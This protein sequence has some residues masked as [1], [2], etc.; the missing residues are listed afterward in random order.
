M[1]SFHPITGPAVPLV[2]FFCCQIRFY[3]D[4]FCHT[5]ILLYLDRFGIRANIVLISIDEVT[6]G[7]DCFHHVLSNLFTTE[8]IVFV[9]GKLPRPPIIEQR[10]MLY[11]FQ[12]IIRLYGGTLRKQFR[13]SLRV[14]QYQLE[15]FTS[16]N[17]SSSLE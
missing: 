6:E 16:I 9:G 14:F 8:F 11:M 2:P 1:G 13:N 4:S 7:E 12:K 5:S 17:W 10:Y 3:F 15:Q